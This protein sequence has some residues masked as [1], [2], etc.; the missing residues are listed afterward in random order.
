MGR[1][2]S[3]VQCDGWSLYVPHLGRSVRVQVCGWSCERY[4]GGAAMTLLVNANPFPDPRE[5]ALAVLDAC[6]DD[7]TLAVALAITNASTNDEKEVEYWLAVAEAL[8]PK[9]NA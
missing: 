3:G 7:V 5:H 8:V 2:A 6:N 9:G 1:G 4:Q